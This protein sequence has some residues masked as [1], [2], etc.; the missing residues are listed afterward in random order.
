MIKHKLCKKYCIRTNDC[1][2]KVNT[3]FD[4]KTNLYALC[5]HSNHCH[6]QYG[7]VS[8]ILLNKITVAEDKLKELKLKELLK[9]D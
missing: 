9:N 5:N 3:V 8:D 1:L 4:A 6:R 2:C 7:S